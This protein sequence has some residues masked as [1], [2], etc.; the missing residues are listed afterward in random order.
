MPPVT[1]PQMP[2]WGR[3]RTNADK[4]VASP[5]A[6]LEDR[7]SHSLPQHQER[8][9]ATNGPKKVFRPRQ[10]ASIMTHLARVVPVATD[11]HT[12]DRPHA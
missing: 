12:V 9:G 6:R 4:I 8:G 5:G 3:N 11:R 10:G 7:L 2:A 1:C